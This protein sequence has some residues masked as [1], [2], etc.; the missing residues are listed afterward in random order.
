[1]QT[2][3]IIVF[4]LF[5]LCGVLAVMMRMLCGEVRGLKNEADEKEA[6]LLRDIE[7]WRSGR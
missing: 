6:E 7:K 2:F 3:L 4:V 5:V 1:M